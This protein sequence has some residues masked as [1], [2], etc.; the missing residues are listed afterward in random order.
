VKARI[1]LQA[2]RSRRLES[3]IA[4]RKTKPIKSVLRL[5]R[6][7]RSRVLI[8][9]SSRRIRKGRG[10]ILILQRIPFFKSCIIR[11]VNMQFKRKYL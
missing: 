7:T 9:G 2:A 4:V 5:E 6:C 3:K 8:S 10:R 1:R 11:E